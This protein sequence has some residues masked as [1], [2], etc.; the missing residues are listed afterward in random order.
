M[1]Q[2]RIDEFR[3]SLVQSLMTLCLLPAFNVEESKV[4]VTAWDNDGENLSN[5]Q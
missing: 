5:Y 1:V 3:S 2:Q 4:K